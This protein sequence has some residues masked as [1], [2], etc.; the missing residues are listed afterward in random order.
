MKLWQ[1]SLR[2]KV[3]PGIV[4]DIWPRHALDDRLRL[5]RSKVR[6]GEPGWHVNKVQEAV[7]I[8]AD[9]VALIGW[10]WFLA[11]IGIGDLI[12]RWL[13]VPGT[14]M[15][16]GFIVALCSVPAWPWLLP[17]RLEDWMCDPRA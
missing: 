16:V 15:V 2:Q 5:G 8:G 11:L 6:N 17:R 7:M 3:Y 4:G 10:I 14:G 1:A 12:G 9:R 13:G